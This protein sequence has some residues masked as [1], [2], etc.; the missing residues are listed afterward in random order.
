MRSE[1]LKNKIRSPFL[2]HYPLYYKHLLM[3][4]LVLSSAS[5]LRY[6]SKVSYFE[7]RASVPLIH[8]SRFYYVQKRAKD[9]IVFL[10]K[11]VIK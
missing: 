11:S 2:P 8:L 5:T 9:W 4:L 1:I 3:Q 10:T 7:S 6:Q